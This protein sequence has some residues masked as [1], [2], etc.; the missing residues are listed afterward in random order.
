MATKKKTVGIRTSSG[1]IRAGGG[2]RDHIVRMPRAV[3]RQSRKG[4]GNPHQR[5]K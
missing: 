2:S 5:G 4:F 3:D 1:E